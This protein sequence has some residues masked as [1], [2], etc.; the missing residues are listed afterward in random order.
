M[1]CIY[2][3]AYNIISYWQDSDND[4]VFKRMDL[5]MLNNSILNCY[6]KVGVTGVSA[7]RPLVAVPVIRVGCCCRVGSA[8]PTSTLH[9]VSVSF[10][11]L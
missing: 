2:R 4:G 9:K 1:L 11:T 10:Y 6:S 3:L 7:T 5:A 8:H